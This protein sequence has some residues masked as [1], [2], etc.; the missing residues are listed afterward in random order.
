M[1]RV[2]SEQINS[3]VGHYLK[4]R[5]FKGD[6][7]HINKKDLKVQQTIEE[8]SLHEACNAAVGVDSSF[9]FSSITGDA[10][11]CD[12]QYVRFRTF[13]QDSVEP[14]RTDLLL[15]LYPVFVH[16]YLEL[17]CNGH[18]T[19]AHK[20]Y[21]RHHSYFLENSEYRMIVE[22]LAQLFHKEDVYSND[23]IRKFREDKFKVVLSEDALQYLF[24]YLKN[25]DNMIMLQIFNHHIHIKVKM[26]T[27]VE[28]DLQDFV[29]FH[30]L[31]LP[32]A[33]DTP[34]NKVIRN[35]VS[36]S[37]LQQ[38]IQKVRDGAP[39]LTS[40]LF[41]TFL[42]THQGLCCTSIS[43]NEALICGGFEENSIK[44]WSLTPSK[45][46]PK[47][48]VVRTDRITMVGDYLEDVE[49]KECSRTR[50]NEVITMRAHSGSVY[51]TAF[52]ADSKYLLSCSE[53][54]SVRLWDLDTYN[55]VALYRGH[56]YAVWD[57]DTS[58][59]GSFFASCS[60]DRTVK[61]W[62]VDRTYPLRTFVGHTM[63]VDCV[64]F[65][66]NCNYVATG[67]GDKSVRLWSVQ[68]GKC[69]R[70]MQ[71]HRGSIYSLAFS[72]DGQ[73]LASAGEDRRIRV[74]DLGTGSIIKELRGHTDIVHSLCF[75][76]ESSMLAS[77]MFIFS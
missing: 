49:E 43:P 31:V 24:R 14:Y 2:R 4:R 25:E 21:S 30:D 74:W 42:N 1:K 10:T 50:P 62:A 72:P 3:Y 36:L 29:N 60:H 69:V 61:L 23:Y 40:I 55:N 47:K 53:D 54:K 35:E 19:P 71:G 34:Q 38:S 7:E 45:L 20:F 5:Q 6:S 12:Q 44:I 66:P 27:D 57:I 39:C 75:N 18:K 63:D 17:I 41:Y 77:G 28:L 70:L 11:A 68:E 58:P 33:P 46:H 76:R 56:S 64:K 73:M 9:S 26:P 15:L 59:S 13:I 22:A 48:A 8:M 37:S 16:V 51:G 32:S 65:H 67:S 52:T